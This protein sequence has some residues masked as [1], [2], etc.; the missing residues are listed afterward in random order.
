MFVMHGPRTLRSR[1][2]SWFVGAILLSA[3]TSILVVSHAR[4]EAL[5]RVEAVAGHIADRLAET[6]DEPEASRAFAAEVR[7]V[8]GF[9]ARLVRDPRRLPPHVRRVAE[10]GATLVP[11]GPEHLVIPVVRSGEV[12]GAL[13]IGPSPAAFRRVVWGW[14]RYALALLLVLAVLSAMAGAVANQLARPLERLARA[15]DRFG[16]GD[17]AF[18][19]DVFGRRRWAAR[20]V[21]DVA[22]SF[23]R[24]A[25]RV[26]AMVRGQR[27]LLGAISHELRS[28]LGRARVALEIARDR[29]AGDSGIEG[30]GGEAPPR[31]PTAALDDVEKQLGDVDTILGDLLDVTRAGLA[32]LRKETRDIVAWVYERVGEEP[33]PPP[34][35]VTAVAG[36]GAT[37]GGPLSLAFDPALLRRA[38]HNLLVNARAH[39]HPPDQPLE[40]G[41]A[42]ISRAGMDWARVTVRDR[43]PGF[44]PAFID[45]AFE[46]FV[47]GDAS[48]ARPASGAG[49]GL[50]LAI[51]K[52]VVEAH[53][54][55]VFAAN[56]DGGGAEVGFELPAAPSHR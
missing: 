47:R 54:G 23:N 56:A 2:F 40:L 7:D 11:E 34:I 45:R 42:V 38:L 51:V 16:G 1:L 29:I 50:G 3:F 17:L 31:S 18:R 33:S 14:G 32:D 30:E 12:I 6:W 48:R 53:G 35:N 37:S 43:G 9:D 41:V 39:G 19:T 49:Y 15:A 4:P 28:P 20:E 26:E 24:M 46:P 8:T 27:E 25:D 22:V 55:R 44:S 36:S 13:E 5:V 52:R 21:R 10:R